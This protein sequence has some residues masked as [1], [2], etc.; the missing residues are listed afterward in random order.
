MGGQVNEGTCPNSLNFPPF[1]YKVF[2][3]NITSLDEGSLEEH[4]Q[5]VLAAG[6]GVL[7]YGWLPD[8]TATTVTSFATPSPCFWPPLNQIYMPSHIL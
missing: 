5:T 2:A 8:T 3:F 7:L 6:H 1:L 4:C